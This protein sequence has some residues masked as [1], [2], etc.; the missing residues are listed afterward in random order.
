[1][2]EKVKIQEFRP[3]DL[4]RIIRQVPAEDIAN[5]AKDTIE[6]ELGLGTT[7]E[8]KAGRKKQIADAKKTIKDVEGR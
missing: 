5:M 8:N 6:D 4:K 2:S 3:K 1:M 7:P